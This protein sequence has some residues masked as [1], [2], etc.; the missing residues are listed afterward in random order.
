MIEAQTILLAKTD[1]DVIGLVIFVVIAAVA[2]LFQWLAKQ[3]QEE[4]QRQQRSAAKSEGEQTERPDQGAQA[5]QPPRQV[6]QPARQ[7]PRV[8]QQA[9]RQMQF[10]PPLRIKPKPPEPVVLEDRPEDLGSGAIEAQK[11]QAAR[12]Q[13]QQQ[14]RQRRLASR[15][16]PEADTAAIEAHLLHIRPGADPAGG[17]AVSYLAPELNLAQRDALRRAILYH[18]IFS[19]PKA[20]RQDRELWDI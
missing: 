17:Q 8:Q 19:P 16:S 2:S 1:I 20:L 18:E 11:S 13:R 10:P 15:K 7:M 12:L 6:A 14:Q 3:R 5:G 9:S 4:K